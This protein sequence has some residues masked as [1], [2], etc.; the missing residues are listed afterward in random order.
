MAFVQ[1]LIEHTYI[2]ENSIIIETLKTKI[3][4][5][6]ANNNNNNNNNIIILIIVIKIANN[7][8]NYKIIIKI[9]NIKYDCYYTLTHTHT[10]KRMKLRSLT[11]LPSMDSCVYS[12]TVDLRALK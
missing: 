8:Y 11:P 6:I 2:I 1:Q 4:T 10:T 5:T 12:E 9:I 7:N 3:I